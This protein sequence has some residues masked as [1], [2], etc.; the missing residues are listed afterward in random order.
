MHFI[1]NDNF[2][3]QCTCSPLSHFIQQNSSGF[4]D[5]LWPAM[6]FI[7]NY[8]QQISKATV[9]KNENW[10]NFLLKEYLIVHRGRVGGEEHNFTQKNTT[11]LQSMYLERTFSFKWMV[12]M[13]I[14]NKIPLVKWYGSFLGF[15]E[16]ERSLPLLI[17]ISTHNKS[18][19]TKEQAF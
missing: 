16:I 5:Y 9:K 10:G 7:W 14:V 13:I 11:I 18:T 12:Q 3:L 1:K 17:L 6:I 2:V 4:E 15:G 19:R 8:W